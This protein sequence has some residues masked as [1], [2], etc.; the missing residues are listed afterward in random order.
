MKKRDRYLTGTLLVLI[1]MV[2]GTLFTLYQ[3]GREFNDQAEV[4][5]T[6]IKRSEAP[7][8]SDEA[9]QKIDSRFLFKTVAKNVTPT[10]VYIETVVSVDGDNF[11]DDESENRED[12]FWDRLLPRRARTVGSGVIISDDGYILTNNHVVEGSERNGIRVVL[13]DKRTYRSRIVGTD[14]TTDL[15]VIKVDAQE[16][17][18]ITIGNSDELEV[19]EWVLAIGNPFQLRS[20]VTA[21]IVSA[22]NRDVNIIEDQM[23]VSS[24]IQTDAA[25]NKG[26]SG[27]A[28]VNTSG[29]LV[30]INTVIMSQNGS[31]QGYGFAVP[32]NLAI[33]V[34]RDIIQYGEVRRALLGISIA[35]VDDS[36]ARSLGMEEIR[37]VVILDLTQPDGAAEESGLRAGDV[38]LSVDGEEVNEANELQ[39][40]IAVQHPGETVN[41]EIWRKGKIL[42][43]EVKLGMLRPQQEEFA[44][45]DPGSSG[46]G[47]EE[48]GEGSG[49][50]FMSF[51][52]GFNVMAL[53][54]E[55]DNTAYDLIIT[56]VFEDTEADRR[57]LKEGYTI[58]R[59]NEQKV[60]DLK[61]LNDIV[62][63]SLRRDRSVIFQIETRDGA[64][65]YYQLK[66]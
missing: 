10:V 30:G 66:Q 48:E 32:S 33:K 35:G 27:G 25:I 21:G 20:T 7:F 54:K 51:D 31:Y 11:Q 13:N 5:F 14:P 1:G 9:L 6:E 43:K 60:E 18:S 24:F 42:K 49:V 63:R 59:V 44:N 36:R 46:R 8:F 52:L 41:L 17:P 57:G 62:E 38:I 39:E 3:E 58:R 29:E 28:L 19:G 40:K 47:E 22:L 2:L 61:T 37:G 4:Q 26:N 53:S 23:R 12:S 55:E 15:A 56:E 64:T 65:G 45:A 50:K 16:L 34:A